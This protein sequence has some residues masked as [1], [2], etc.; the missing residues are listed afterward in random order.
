[1]KKTIA[2]LVLALLALW[3]NGRIWA[4]GEEDFGNA[5]LNAANFG[6][7]PG[8][9]PLVNHP[10]RVYHIWVNGN[11]HFFYRG[12]T[13]ALNDALRKFAA[14]KAE[15]HEVLLR[16]GPCKAETF[17][18]TKTIPYS[19]SLHIVGG[20][21]RHLTTLELGSKVWSKTPTLTICVGKDI[22]LE[23]VEIPKGVSIVGIADLSRR[24]REAFTS[25]DQTVR[26]WAAGE[27]A[28]L[29]P[30]DAENMAAIAKL[31]NDKVDWV[32]SNAAGAL[33]IFGKNAESVVPTL[34][35][36]LIGTQDK[37]LKTTIERS[38]KDIQQA[39]DSTAAEEEHRTILKKIREFLSS[40]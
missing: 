30:Y 31:L 8:I 1:M 34:R 16:P 39:K 38:I 10:S 12:D 3:L 35:Q 23:K 18:S 27:L 19:W 21:A 17:D 14:S 29:D 22:D 37:Q 6:S 13:A 36:V 32:R 24:Y 20:I 26:G 2:I 40:R 11:E 15:V 9:M 33:T 7:W 4:A 5:A 28:R 25:K